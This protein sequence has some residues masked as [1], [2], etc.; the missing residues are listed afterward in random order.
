MSGTNI[1][2]DGHQSWL[3]GLVKAAQNKMKY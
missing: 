2:I 1:M 3:Y